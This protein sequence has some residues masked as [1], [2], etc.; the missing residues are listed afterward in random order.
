MADENRVELEVDVKANLGPL[1]EFQSELLDSIEIINIFSRS[2]QTF[3][4]EQSK[5]ANSVKSAAK[6]Q[7]QFS[8]AASEAAD[9]E[10]VEELARRKRGARLL[11][12]RVDA[13]AAQKE[14]RANFNL[15]ARANTQDENRVKVV[16][17]LTKAVNRQRESVFAL[18]KARQLS[19][20][21]GRR[22]TA[23]ELRTL[24]VQDQA[25][26]AFASAQD[27][28]ERAFQASEDRVK[29]LDVETRLLK[30]KT[31]AE[32]DAEVAARQAAVAREDQRKASEAAAKRGLTLEG[33]T[34]EKDAI[35]REA[36]QRAERE[37]F[38]A[39]FRKDIQKR[40]ED[41][42]RFA[43]ENE[44]FKRA[45]ELNRQANVD[46]AKLRDRDLRDLKDNILSREPIY[47]KDYQEAR[48]RNLKKLQD[49]QDARN[50]ELQ[51]LK[52]DIE[53]RTALQEAEDKR[54]L[55]SFKEAFKL[56]QKEEARLARAREREARKRAREEERRRRTDPTGAGFRAVAAAR[57]EQEKLQALRQN[58]ELPTILAQ[59][60]LLQEA[61]DLENK[62]ALA[63]ERAG[64]GFR[65]QGFYNNSLE[66]TNNI[67]RQISFSFRRLFG[68]LALFAAARALVNAFNQSL[69]AVVRFQ[70]NLEQ[71]E[72]GIASIIV[73]SG[74]I[75]DPFGKAV[76]SARSLAFAQQV[77]REQTDLLRVDALQTAATFEELADAFQSAIAPGVQ[78]G[79]SLGEIREFS[80]RISQAAA[81][82]GV[83]QRQLAEEIRSL[84]QGTVRVRDTRIAVALGITN[85][86]IKRAKEL[87]QLGNFLTERFKA[88]GEA[89][90]IAE[91]NLF[92]LFS[93]TKDAF[94][95]LSNVA[96]ADFFG[97]LKDILNDIRDTIIET[98]DIT[99]KI[100]F[101]P[102]AI[103][104]GEQ[105]F[106][107][108]KDATDQVSILIKGLSAE[109][110]LDT[111]SRLRSGFQVLFESL[112]ILT[113]II[114]GAV[115]DA[116][117]I[118]G[119]LGSAVS[120][121]ASS[122]A[123]LTGISLK[124]LIST[125]SALLATLL[126]F[127]GAVL[128]I[129][130][131]IGSLKGLLLL[132]LPLKA[133]VA[134]L[135][136]LVVNVIPLATRVLPKVATA[137]KLALIPFV[138][139]TAAL[140]LGVVFG[141]A[142]AAVYESLGQAIRRGFRGTA[143]LKAELEE[144]NK[145]L[146]KTKA[147][148]NEDEGLLGGSNRA[149]GLMLELAELEE[150]ASNL[151]A[152]LNESDIDLFEQTEKN[153]NRF[154]DK[155]KDF[156]TSEDVKEVGE[157]LGDTLTEGID[158]S[159]SIK[160]A[161]D[162][163]FAISSIGASFEDQTK[164][165]EDLNDEL[166]ELS[167]ESKIL[168]E[169]YALSNNA[170]SGLVD[171]EKARLA[172]SKDTRELVA[173]RTNLESTLNATLLDQVKNE[174]K[175]A[176][177]SEAVRNAVGGTARLMKQI[178]A[179]A[180]EQ[181]QLQL[182]ISR[183]NIDRNNAEDLGDLQEKE[184]IERNIK[185]LKDLVN[186][187]EIENLTD[188]E[189]IK[190]SI[191]LAE[192]KEE[193]S[194]QK[195][196]D[197]AT[198]KLASLAKELGTKNAIAE[199][200]AVI[201][202]LEEA[203]VKTV[204]EQI[205]ISAIQQIKAL[206][207]QTNELRIQNKDRQRAI[208]LERTAATVPITAAQIRLQELRNRVRLEKESRLLTLKANQEQID[209]LKNLRD[210]TSSL[211]TRIALEGQIASLQ[212][213]QSEELRQ[214]GLL[215]DDLNQK[216]QLTKEQQETP[217]FSGIQEGLRQFAGENL[218]VFQATLDIMK[219][220]LNS[221]AEA[222]AAYITSI[223]DPSNTQTAR[224]RLA[225]FLLQMLQLIIATYIKIAIARAILAPEVAAANFVQSNSAKSMTAQ[226]NKLQPFTFKEGG[227]IPSGKFMPTVHHMNNK[228]GLE[229]GGAVSLAGPPNAKDTV[230]I[231]AQPGEFMMRLSAVQKYGSGV[232]QALNKGLIDPM[233]LRGLAGARK[234]SS[235]L[236]KTP[237]LAFNT[238]GNI[239]MAQGSGSSSGSN[240]GYI[241]ANEKQMEML[242]GG[243]KNS[244]L[245][246]MN[247]NRGAIRGILGT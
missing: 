18:S 61:I 118:L 64:K 156:F 54:R 39:D 47:E 97:G 184:K 142:L 166:A 87:G 201:N 241:V 206:Q 174:A 126:G 161:L 103:A 131:L 224:Q 31:K 195:I 45:K 137:A 220:S 204:E 150:E 229:T 20:K 239:G 153:L 100:T 139:L 144:V 236:N 194:G 130:L 104:I 119:T 148:L 219:S 81:A 79:L 112:R 52:E 51:A 82:I 48:E 73:A 227:E 135:R 203:R 154:K 215:I 170:V 121:A 186:K 164:I 110:T 141:S 214:Q 42:E 237:R 167:S 134:V 106:G 1:Q 230:P 244:M 129:Q 78:A 75:T 178:N 187:A 171:L 43:F 242:L 213:L 22:A 32:I 136:I 30:A 94:L 16:E 233:A 115:Q 65:L 179:R 7:K 128:V 62:K 222:G 211:F 95:Q 12:Q 68:V 198:Q 59:N 36:Q 234:A 55:K 99:D 74:K 133:L 90:K 71:I 165:I 162:A 197:L 89:G 15:A 217:I 33:K 175:V 190:A 102:E 124:D 53:R 183:L 208:A 111:L 180:G 69:R 37:R 86:D 40:R 77:A 120:D 88:F 189:T 125:T 57:K 2:L 76:D 85:Q 151:Q 108:L 96:G 199:I 247:N 10:R 58:R 34:F 210:N 168:S 158:F 176:T 105:F 149:P 92:V 225:R 56:Q 70:A 243:G 72:L 223:F 160:Q 157:D 182:K 114:I 200:D 221:F 21:L 238:G 113:Q 101:N 205:K 46:A 83:P 109:G 212:A 122:L 207:D 60:K 216:I 26:L 17:R 93:N 155:L 240:F 231:W 159:D 66:R 35:D 3:R 23:S 163:A 6:S 209:S 107:I 11:K 172:T 41:P 192:E 28:Y 67:V 228:K 19:L 235:F 49:S 123:E 226:F 80:V 140:A 25:V 13:K 147:L 191:A 173:Q 143:D 117:S 127:R 29:A 91:Q 24:G 146:Q 138:K 44:Q 4:Q 63:I 152:L 196:I 193:G 232:M 84:L 218:D 246:F 14:V 145:K 9:A 5:F 98:D 169:N 188:I 177:S 27:T 116:L 132:T 185:N 38:L 245:D 50:K 8:S 181:A 202:E